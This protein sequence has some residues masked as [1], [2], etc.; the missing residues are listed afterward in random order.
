MGGQKRRRKRNGTEAAPSP[1]ILRSSSLGSSRD[2]LD[3]NPVLWAKRDRWL[4]LERGRIEQFHSPVLGEGGEE[5][6]RFHPGERF[7]DAG[8]R[9]SAEGEIGVAWAIGLFEPAL[10]AKALRVG[11]ESSVAV[12]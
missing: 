7:T 10:R 2:Q 8:A 1:H 11:P 9:A 3:P 6:R 5:Q 4:H 12:G